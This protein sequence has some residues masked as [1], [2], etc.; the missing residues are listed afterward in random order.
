MPKRVAINGFGR[1][2]RAV[3]KV[4]LSK[5]SKYQIVAINDLGNWDN[6]AYL[7][8]YDSAYGRY[9]KPV[10]MV[11][12]N[13][14]IGNK[15]IPVLSDP[16]PAK[17]PWKR[18]KVDVVLECTGAF[19]KKEEAGKH[20][21][22]G[23]KSVIISAP[24]N[25]DGIVTVVKGVNEKMAKNAGVV[26]NASCTTN[27]TG[28]VMAVLESVFGVEKALLTTIHAV[29]ASQRTVDLPTEDDYRRGR[30]ALNNLIPTTT[31]A[32]IATTLTLPSLKDKFDGISIRVPITAL[33]RKNTS[34]KEINNAFIKY[35]KM[36]RFRGI[37]EVTEDELV[38]SDIIGT[39][40]SAI[41]DLKFTKVVD[42]NL[43]K[44][45]A[46]YDNEWGY[47]NRLAEMV[48]EV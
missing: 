41:V 37:L 35:S 5:G 7:M 2:G 39:A 1:I 40:A 19:T 30:S 18:L 10:E 27:C 47:S 28:P 23:A 46:W 9:D 17:L 36:P 25:S 3:A 31:G 38:S 20:L 34:V 13:L 24:S 21:K 44:I 22:A 48:D 4:L 12:K 33:L 26:A 29:T 16:N 14:K 42:G 6:L 11:G 43:V 15:L 8:K 32:A 45:L